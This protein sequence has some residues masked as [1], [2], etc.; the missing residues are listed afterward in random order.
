MKCISRYLLWILVFSLLPAAP[1]LSEEKAA[2][3]YVGPRV[4]LTG[5]LT[6]RED[7]D[8]MIQEIYPNDREYFPLYSRIGLSVEQR[9]LSKQSESYLSIQE[10]FFVGGLDQ[11]FALPFISLLIN[12]H[13]AFGLELA[14]GPDFSLKK[15]SGKHVLAPAL[16]YAVGWTFA[17]GKTV[18]PV[19]L[20][21]VPISPDGKPTLTLTAGLDFGL[22]FKEKKKE[23]LPFN[24]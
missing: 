6:D 8:S 13:T 2:W 24:Y 18:L 1:L 12:F 4:G 23:T 16:V 20:S 7:F 19:T 9:I 11:T 5:V 17:F 21:S 22:K 14:L 15:Q 3:L 10:L